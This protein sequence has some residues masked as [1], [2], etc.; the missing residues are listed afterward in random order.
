MQR[1]SNREYHAL[2]FNNAGEAAAF[3][4]SLS[5]FLNSPRTNVKP[6]A[7]EI[8]CVFSRPHVRLYLSEAAKSAAAQA[9]AP[10]PP[11]NRCTGDELYL[12]RL[13]LGSLPLPVWGVE[14]AER[15]LLGE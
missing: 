13:V 7:V 3:V 4:A 15:A 9:F 2:M 8:W 11:T 1:T 6:E 12:G 5:R 14:E 10:L